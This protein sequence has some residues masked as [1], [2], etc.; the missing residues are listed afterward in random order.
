M[1]LFL[2][3]IQAFLFVFVGWLVCFFQKYRFF[4]FYL[5]VMISVFELTSGVFVF[6]FIFHVCIICFRVVVICPKTTCEDKVTERQI[7]QNLPG[8][9]IK[10]A[11]MLWAWVMNSK[12]QLPNLIIIN[13]SLTQTLCN[14]IN[15][16]RGIGNWGFCISCGKCLQAC[17]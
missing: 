12:H 10:L 2:L 11:D 1:F 6:F 17:N 4:C 14:A 9:T 13:S 16:E 15:E 3:Q 5:I 7:T 8:T